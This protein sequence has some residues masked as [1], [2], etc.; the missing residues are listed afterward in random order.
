MYT[1]HTY[2]AELQSPSHTLEIIGG[3]VTMDETWSP[4]IQGTLT[5]P[6]PSGSVLADLDPRANRRV[7][8]TATAKDAAG[9]TLTTRTWDL[10]LRQVNV[11]YEDATVSLTLASD[12]A[13]VQDY[14]HYQLVDLREAFYPWSTRYAIEGVLFYALGG[15]TVAGDDVSFEPHWNAQNNVVNPSFEGASVSAYSPGTGASGLV[16]S[17]TVA[18]V[19]TRSL[20]WTVGTGVSNLIIGATQQDYRASAGTYYSVGVMIISSNVRSASLIVRFKDVFGNDLATHQSAISNTSTSSWQP[21]EVLEVLAPP[22]TAW[23]S[24]YVATTG[25][26]SGQFHYID[27][28]YI[29]EG[30]VNPGYFS[31][32]STLPADYTYAWNGTADAS[33]STRTATDFIADPTAYLW[34]AG[35]NAWD[36]CQVLFQRDGMRLWCDENRD[37]QMHFMAS[38]DPGGSTTLAYGVDLISIDD[39]QDR[40]GKWGEAAVITYSYESSG[41][42]ITVT[43]YHPDPFPSGPVK[44]ITET[45]N[46]PYPGAGYAQY[47]VER[48]ATLGRAMRLVAVSNYDTEPSQE[49]TATLPDLPDATGRIRSVTW[50]FDNDTMTI[51]TRDAA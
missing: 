11:N 5:I 4:Y 34:R 22:G 35:Q 20:R 45:I 37:W 18:Y 51:E 29:A 6:M 39:T 3:S 43:E 41:S 33:P 24:P 31:G 25:N 42:P 2:T 23:I 15:A 10:S 12:E 30:E 36:F 9:S 8:V 48:H 7:T 19:G 16:T 14:A 50:D 46:R 49:F 21:R 47:L 44:V 1:E 40:E 32:A 38:Y 13:I 17:T 27:A 28:V 26:V